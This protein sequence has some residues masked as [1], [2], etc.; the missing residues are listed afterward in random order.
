MEMHYDDVFFTGLASGTGVNNGASASV[1]IRDASGGTANLGNRLDFSCNVNTVLANDTAFFFDTC[2]DSDGDGFASAVCGGADCDDGSPAVFPGA[3]EVCNGVDDDCDPL[4]DETVDGDGDGFTRCD[5]DCDD[6]RAAAFP[7]ATETCDGTDED[8][9]GFAGPSNT[10]FASPITVLSSAFN[11]GSTLRGGVFT[12]D[13]PTRLQTLRYTLGV[14]TTTTLTWLVYEVGPLSTGTLIA[15]VTSAANSVGKATRESP[16][17]DVPLQPG[18]S[19][20]FAVSTG[21]A[22]L[23]T[24][25]SP[26]NSPT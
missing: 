6:T 23:V 11:G 17:L 19:Y 22:K 5:G 1:F 10:Y 21:A 24:D 12:F 9:D 13:R 16:P 2:P 18:V 25:F 26:A 8:C 7:N 15:S 3:T 20:A 4:T 14:S